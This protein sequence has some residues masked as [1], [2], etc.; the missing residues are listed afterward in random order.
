M[1]I[2]GGFSK[3]RINELT[4]SGI[5]SLFDSFNEGI[6]FSQVLNK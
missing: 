6:N 3:R 5:F 1:A 4:I 2:S